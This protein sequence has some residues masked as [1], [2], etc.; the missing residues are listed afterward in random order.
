MD[1]TAQMPWHVDL[2]VHTRRYSPC[3][4]SL[5]A[6]QLPER[7]IACGLHGLVITEHDHLWPRADIARLNHQL[8][9]ARIYRG[10]EVSSCNGHFLVIGLDHMDGLE[11]GIS[12]RQLVRAAKRQG[13]AVILAHP[14]LRY[15]QMQDPLDL[16][17]MPAGIDAVEVAST[18]TVGHQADEVKAYAQ[19]MGYAQV[20]GS[21]AH[22]LPHVG[23]VVTL[24]PELPADEQELA[25]TI[26][27]GQCTAKRCP[28]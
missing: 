9:G 2:H 16:S 19:Q 14:Q 25:A 7:M 1:D 24:F 8:D 28:Q 13:A 27:R 4:E 11:P 26:R 15:S 23:R 3:A 5:D 18:V 10:V 12:A 21:D 17:E 20:G 22:A 6:E